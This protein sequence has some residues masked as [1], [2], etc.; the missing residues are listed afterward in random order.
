MSNASVLLPLPRD[1]G[2]DGELVARDVDVDVLEV[3]LA[4]VV[5]VDRI[6]GC[7]ALRRV[8]LGDAHGGRASRGPSA[9]VLAAARAGVR[10]AHARITSAGV[11]AQTISPPASPPSGPEVDDPVGGADHVEVVLDHDA[12][13]GRRRELAEGAQQLGDVVEVQARGR[14]VEQEQRA[15]ARCGCAVLPRWLRR[16]GRRASAAAPRRPR[17]WAPAGPAQVAEADVGQRLPARAAPR[18]RRRRTRS[19]SVTVRSST[20]AMLGAMAVAPSSLHFQHLGAD[21]A[22]RRSRG[23]AGRRR[24]GT[25]SRR[26]RSRCRR[27]SGSG[28]CRR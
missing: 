22:G 26:A 13:N 5:D 4:R 19:A 11:P 20:S 8:A 16:D 12:A 3:V 17:A 25:A 10:C 23:S 28:R 7:A 6:A 1:A 27:R 14:L 15:L 21:S 2:D 24:R 18:G 9:L